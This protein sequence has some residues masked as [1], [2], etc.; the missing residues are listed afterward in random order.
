MPLLKNGKGNG[1]K[2]GQNTEEV[3]GDSDLAITAFM[4]GGFLLSVWLVVVMVMNLIAW[5]KGEMELDDE[6]DDYL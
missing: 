3:M 1:N 2:T 4:I 6:D 5:K